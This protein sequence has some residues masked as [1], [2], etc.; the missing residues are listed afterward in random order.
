MRYWHGFLEEAN[1][2]AINT[3]AH[4]RA[5]GIAKA[6]GRGARATR[7]ARSI[8]AILALGRYWRSGCLWSGTRHCGDSCALRRSLCSGR[9]LRLGW[10]CDQAQ[11]FAHFGVELGHGVFIVFQELAGVFAALADALA[12]VAEPGAGFFEDVVV[13]GDV[14]QIAFARDAFAVEDVELGFAEGRGDFVFD[15]FYAGA[16]AGDYI[17]FLDGGDAADI[18]AH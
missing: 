14:E 3:P 11:G 1:H 18:H 2:P 7:V 16:R 5:H 10:S 15:D 4:S 6:R 8:R 17:A 9:R 13:H 12:F